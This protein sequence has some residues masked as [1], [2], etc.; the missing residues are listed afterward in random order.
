MATAGHVFLLVIVVRVI[1]VGAPIVVVTIFVSLLI[2]VVLVT[3]ALRGVS[4][5]KLSCPLL[6]PLSLNLLLGDILGV[7][8]SLRFLIFSVLCLWDP[9]IV[10][11]KLHEVVLLRQMIQEL[12]RL[13]LGFLL[14]S[15]L[16]LLF[17]ASFPLT[18]LFLHLLVLFCFFVVVVLLKV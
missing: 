6:G 2:V 10:I 7:I 17:Q 1:V 18:T 13:Q 12:P 5:L 9:Q 3:T 15:K 14:C 8:N 4:I 16:S 11:H